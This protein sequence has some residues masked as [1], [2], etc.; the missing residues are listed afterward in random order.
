MNV[1]F[2]Y[3]WVLWAL[4]FL[5]PMMAFNVFR[6]AGK[7]KTMPRAFKKRIAASTVF[8]GLFLAGLIIALASPRWGSGQ[9]ASTV[10]RAVDVVIAL[11]L[12][13]SMDV[14]DI[15]AS[16]AGGSR[17][18]NNARADDSPPENAGQSGPQSGLQSRLQRGL[19][20]AVDTVAALPEL[21]F[22]AAV[23]RGRG[24]LAVPLT[25]D[26]GAVMNFLEAVDGRLLTGRGTNL[27]S[28]IDAA[29]SAFQDSS[30]AQRCILLVSDGE[31]LS[32][33]FRAAVERC[34]QNNIAIIALAL[35]SDSGQAVP[36]L[37]DAT[38]SRDYRAM[39]MAADISGGLY[40]DGNSGGAAAAVTAYLRSRAPLRG[41]DSESAGSAS[42]WFLFV[43]IAIVCYG[44]SVLSVREI[45]IKKL[46]FSK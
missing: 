25:P 24:V 22:A 7:T 14:R 5:V 8:F 1:S 40:V 10:R 35:G 28:L 37:D 2:D 20:L 19:A 26:S 31:S 16:G 29:V 33:S 6:F 21:R 30:P 13:R 27:E 36:G 3:P 46:G 32:G 9:L 34:K 39:Y 17:I 12:S 4:A 42:R 43:I 15:S 11:D 23:G 44:A 41:A 18:A 38:S 45:R